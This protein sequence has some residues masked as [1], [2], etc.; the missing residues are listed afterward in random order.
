MLLCTDINYSKINKLYSVE[1][2]FHVITKICEYM[3]V[4]GCHLSILINNVMHGY[5]RKYPDMIV[6]TPYIKSTF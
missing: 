2:N 5:L 3:C 4:N 6:T 1:L